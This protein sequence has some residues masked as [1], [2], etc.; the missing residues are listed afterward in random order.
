MENVNAQRVAVGCS[1]WLGEKRRI[2][3][4]Y[5]KHAN[6]HQQI[7][8]RQNEDPNTAASSEVNG[9]KRECHPDQ[10]KE[11]RPHKPWEIRYNDE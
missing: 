5:V 6:C 1:D 3:I 8:R 11:R 2:N 10:G 7:Q 4:R 9:D